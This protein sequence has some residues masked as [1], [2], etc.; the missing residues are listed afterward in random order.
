MRSISLFFRNVAKSFFLVA[1]LSITVLANAQTATDANTVAEQ[2]TSGAP[3]ADAGGAAATGDA[4][5]GGAIFK[6]KCTAC[7]AIDKKVLGPALKGITER[8][9][10]AWLIKWIK[11][12]QALI[13]AG[14][15]AAVKVFNEYNKVVMPGFPE[16]SD[17]D[18]NNML[19]YI[20][21]E[22]AAPAQAAGAKGG[23][24]GAEGGQAS[25]GVSDFLLGGLIVLVIIA[26]FVI[27]VL[28]RV[29]KTLERL[30][31][32]K[33][34]VDITEEESVAG[35]NTAA[36]FKRLSKNKK[37]GFSVLLL[38]IFLG[39]WGWT[40]MWNTG[41]HQ[42]YQPEQPIK[43]SHQLHAGTL[44]IDCQYCHF[45][46]Y[47]SK[48]AAIPSLNVCMNCH[49]YITASEKYNGETSPEIAK[50]Y[51]ALDYDPETKVYGD[52]PKPVQWIRIHNLPD[53]AYFNHSQHV[54]VA[55]IKCQE[56]HGP[57]QT[58]KEVYQYSPLTMKWCINCHKTRDVN[59]KGNAYYDKILTVHEQLKQGKQVTPA[60]LGG[61]ECGK[62]HY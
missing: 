55:G 34:G 54:K 21:A 28:N 15:P 20:D 43:Y 12:S 7:H 49:N 22:S 2:S 8:H 56:C 27:L 29:I 62:C 9:D 16:L 4:A 36:R 57:I 59:Y 40:A 60:V 53:L 46:A 44:K 42:G 24:A 14:D 47:K 41:V 50:I 37:F 35:E 23:A 39:S 45:S 17:A 48:N 11:N 25:E 13:A 52:N 10:N 1:F 61:L 58:M 32:Q 26:L 30:I 38:V 6:Q 51:K 33:Q 5:A 3:A 31:L 19:A 18:I